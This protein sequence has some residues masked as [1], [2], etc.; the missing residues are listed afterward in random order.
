MSKLTPYYRLQSRQDEQG[1]WWVTAL[2][3]Y[4][5]SSVLPLIS[6]QWRQETIKA[7]EI[8]L[9]MSRGSLHK[10]KEQNKKAKRKPIIF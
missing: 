7:A 6:T 8:M 3:I 1:A 2:P 10:C 5:Y 4:P 9:I